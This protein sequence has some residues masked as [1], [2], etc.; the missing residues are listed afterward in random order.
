M[1]MADDTNERYIN[2]YI[3]W[4]FVLRNLYRL[5][6]RPKA[7]QDRVFQKLKVSLLKPFLR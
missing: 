1:I 2:P 5:W 4:M 3:E 7:L 6:E